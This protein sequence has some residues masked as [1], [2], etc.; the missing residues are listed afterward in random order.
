MNERTSIPL[1]DLIIDY[2]WEGEFTEVEV[3]SIDFEE[4]SNIQEETEEIG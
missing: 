1:K 4:Y 2:V 3:K